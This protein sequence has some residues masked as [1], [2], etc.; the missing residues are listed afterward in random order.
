MPQAT[1][2]TRP[3][4]K[5]TPRTTPQ[6]RRAIAAAGIGHFVEY[7]DYTVY[8]FVASSIAL[9]FFPSEDPTAS[10]LATFAAFALAFAA[11]P[12]GG[13]V[14]S[15]FGDRMGRRGVLAA[16]VLMMGAGAL[17]L[18]VTPTYGSIGVAAPLLL[19]IARL[20]QGF[21]TGG[22]NAGAASF[23]LEYAPRNRRGFFTS[24]QMSALMAA[25]IF[26]SGFCALLRTVM[27]GDTFDTWGWRIPFL[28]GAALA[29]IGLYVRLRLDDTPA[30]QRVEGTTAVARVPLV[31]TLRDHWRDVLVCTGFY[32]SSGVASYVLLV[33]M[34]TYS[35]AEF[36]VSDTQAL[37]SNTLALA[38]L[39]VLIPLAGSLSD[40]I[41]RR[42]PLLIFNLGLVV[43]SFPLIAFMAEGGFVRVLLA[44]LI[45][46][47]LSA[48]FF[49]AGTAAAGELFPTRVRFTGLALGNNVATALFGGTAPF[50]A[51]W[52]I[53]ETGS[54]ISPAFMLMAAGAISLIVVWPMR[55]TSEEDLRDTE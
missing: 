20:M 48:C 28:V 27:P 35:S 8:G 18:G 55:E 14:F 38:A 41:G 53:A 7:Y 36:G 30:F 43:L 51:T 42:P 1:P 4:E 45:F 47:V 15:H 5:P 34:P 54:S 9:N 13:L 25:M 12:I 46:A 3:G 32:T 21:S 44:Q 6:Q 23:L 22:E 33:Y 50:L 26:G 10:M 29:L 16:S 31:D 37:Y 2:D 17:I 39:G 52:L 49:G 19:V 11:R 24:L 40:R